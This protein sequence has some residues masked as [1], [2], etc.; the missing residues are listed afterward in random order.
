[1][2]LKL[3]VRERGSIKQKGLNVRGLWFLQLFVL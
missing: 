2:G 1:M 3:I